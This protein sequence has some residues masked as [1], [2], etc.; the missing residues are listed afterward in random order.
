[1]KKKAEKK[2][3]ISLTEMEVAIAEMYGVAKHLIVTNVSWGMDMHECDILVLRPTGYALE[4]EIKRSLADMKKD[5]EKKHGHVDRQNR[6]KELY[7]AFPDDICEKC[8]VHLPAGAGVILVSRKTTGNVRAKII[9]PATPVKNARPFDEKEISQLQRLAAM[10][11][12][13]AKRR[14]IRLEKKID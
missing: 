2:R 9:K 14:I 7:F 5:A 8:T 1:M 10:R 13:T 6:L 11:A 4:I 3:R 12:W